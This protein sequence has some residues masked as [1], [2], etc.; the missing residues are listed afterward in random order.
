MLTRNMIVLDQVPVA[1]SEDISISTE[2]LSNGNLN[3]ENG[4]VQWNFS[5]EPKQEIKFNLK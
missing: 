4:E 5:L 1:T 3:E 2:N